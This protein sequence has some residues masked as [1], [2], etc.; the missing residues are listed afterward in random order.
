MLIKRTIIGMIVGS[1]IIALGAYSLVN[2]LGP[3]ISMDE[4]YVIASGENL[5][6]YN[7]GTKRCT[8]VYENSW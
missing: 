8:T 2:I 1:I 4:D 7:S 5:L 6:L 3:T